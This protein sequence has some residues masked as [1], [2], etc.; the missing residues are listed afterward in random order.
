V[1]L[2]LRIAD[3]NWGE[4]PQA[5]IETVARL[6]VGAFE[7]ALSGTG[8]LDLLLEQNE[9]PRAVSTL[10]DQGEFVIHLSGPSMYCLQLTY[11]LGHEFTHVM[12]GPLDWKPDRFAWFEECLADVGSLFALNGV[13]RNWES[14]HLRPGWDAN[15]MNCR[16]YAANYLNEPGRSLSGGVDFKQWLTS[17]LPSLKVED[18][19][20]P[21]FTIIA[22]HLLPVF[23]R[24]PTAWRAIRYLHGFERPAGMTFAEFLKS[25][26]DWCPTESQHTVDVIAA[27]LGVSYPAARTRPRSLQAK[28]L[29]Y[30]AALRGAVSRPRPASRKKPRSV[31]SPRKTKRPGP[32][33]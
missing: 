27:A 13:A 19:Q 14:Q 11:Q 31:R 25:W 18:A 8:R 6:V 12:A 23:E 33:E 10:S 4:G 2:N 26:R 5:N 30:M 20:R 16:I 9:Q 22:R 24:D 7:P 29:Q 21:R 17:E 15:P 3:N 32:A 28:A 1:Q